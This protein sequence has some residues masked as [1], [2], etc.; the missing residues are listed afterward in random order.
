[1]VKNRIHGF[2][3]RH[4]MRR[5][6]GMR[7]WTRAHRR[8]LC[9]TA[10]QLGEG[11]GL[12]SLVRQLE[13]YENEIRQAARSVRKL[14]ST[15]RYRS[16]VSAMTQLKGVGLLTAM[17][18][19]TELGGLG[20]FG[21]RRELGNYPGLTP[22]S[23]ESGEGSG[24]KGR[25][26]RMGPARLRKVLNQAAWSVVRFDPDWKDWLSGKKSKKKWIT[27]VMRKLG[28]WLWRQG[29]AAA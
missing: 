20:R 4:G 22:K 28:I 2:L 6:E 11:E 3:K 7:C 18:C 5:P 9:E 19:L 14:S 23:C 16:K 27:A 1:M 17:V 29:L 26:S 10:S 25:I 8:W 15:D 21:N 24:R 12:L 13:F